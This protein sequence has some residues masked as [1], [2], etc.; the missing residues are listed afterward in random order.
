VAE[1]ERDREALRMVD[2][3]GVDDDRPGHG[4]HAETL[5]EGYARAI[6]LLLLAGMR[7]GEVGARR[8][9]ARSDRV[10]DLEDGREAD[11]VDA[12]GACVPALRPR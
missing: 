5:S 6:R 4:W 1:R 9:E 2:L 12:A 8:L 3:F 11:P 7:R 10:A